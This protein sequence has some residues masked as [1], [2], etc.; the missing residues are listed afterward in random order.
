MRVWLVSAAPGTEVRLGTPVHGGDVTER[1]MQYQF[2]VV[3]FEA[4]R[5]C[6]LRCPMCMTGSNDAHTVRRSFHNE[7]TLEEIRERIMLPARRLGIHTIAWS[8]GEFLMRKDADDLLRLTVDL[9]FRC[10]VLSNCK[11]LTRQR[12][13]RIHDATGGR[14]RIVVGLNAVDADNQWSRDNGSERTIQVLRDCAELG[15]NQ[16]VVIT[17]GKYN[18]GSFEKTV[19]FCVTNG[20]AYN[21]SPL[22]PRGSGANCFAGLGFDR[23][24]LQQ[25][26]HPVL[27]R[28]PHGY[29]S[30]TPYFL[31]PELHA[32]VSGGVRNNT[33]PQNPSI[34]CWVGSWLTINAEGDVSVCPVLLDALS[35]GNVREKPIDELVESSP[36]FATITDRSRL[37]GRCGRCRYQYTCGGCRALAFYH[38]GDYLGE[39]P[40]CFFEPVD[41]STVSEHE[42]E[43][44]RIFMQYLLMARAAGAYQPPA[45]G[46]RGDPADTAAARAV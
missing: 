2:Q 41:Q 16:H 12:L 9:G 7:L 23:D 26:F 11:K 17:I 8:G 37:K 13:Q 39:D 27:R 30:Y 29:V 19:D 5:R 31:S 14:A 38:S 45:G 33:V 1:A 28:R 32:R 36:L 10:S 25:H 20:I 34:G 22:V 42:A 21:R 4:T 43:T 3:Y 15:L 40:T 24:D 35:G 46:Q 44:N 18:T 6:N